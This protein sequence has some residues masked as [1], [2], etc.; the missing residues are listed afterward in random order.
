MIAEQHRGRTAIYPGS[1]DPVTNGHLDLIARS[2]KLVDRLIVAILQNEAKRPLFTAEERMDMIRESVDANVE[3]ASF[4]G[5]LADYAT[6]QGA[7]LIVRGI[8]GASDYENESRM[9]RMNRR[10]APGIETI[11]LIAGES[12]SFVSSRLVKEV[13]G[14]GGDISGLVP[15]AVARRLR[16]RVLTR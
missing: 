2:A 8:R 5:L 10:L 7:S 11:F 4:E 9:A 6:A 15:P 12:H 16:D 1:F 13:A 3:V 14:F